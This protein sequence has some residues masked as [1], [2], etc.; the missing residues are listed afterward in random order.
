MLSYL[1][2]RLFT[3]PFAFLPYRA[4]HALGKPLGTLAY[5]LIPKYRKR[6]LSNLALSDLNLTTE[7]LKSTAKKSLQSL[8]ITVL[9][10]PKLARETTISRIVTCENPEEADAIMQQG[11]GVIFFCGHQANWELLF[12]E[13]T[14][15]MP[16]VAIGRPTKNK[17][18]Y[19]WVQG[20]RQKFG[21]TI[22]A[23]KNALKEGLR[24]LKKGA[25]LGIVGDQGM[26]DSGYHCPFL[27]REAWTS[28]APAMLSYKTNTPLIV[29]TTTRKNGRYTIH[30]EKALYPDPNAPMEQEIDRLMRA[31]LALY[32]NSIRK[33]PH[34]WLW[35][36]NRWKQQ[37]VG[38]LKRRYREDSIA[39]FLP[40]T[41][42]HLA[43]LPLLRELYPTE[44]I[45]LFAPKT[46][47]EKITLDAEIRPYTN[48][49]ELLLDDY[50][51]KL[52]FDL[53]CNAK[54]K[55]HYKKRSAQ[56]IVHPKTLQ[57]LE[58]LVRNA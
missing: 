36:H 19:N 18:L 43:D 26:P 55:S 10:Y 40:E 56:T 16:G 29:A 31:A 32:E 24:A 20:I 45:T 49:K 27:G 8:M 35:I 39:L 11:K 23:P 22:V 9:E 38:A 34:E 54:I 12:L 41:E 1:I 58:T 13:G 17:H 42:T 44:H 7:Q 14:S 3:L 33:H 46:L 5:Y 21:G 15:R 30:Y 4:I 37:P 53:T 2:L 6:A 25:F 48:P 47:A 57:A 50:R 28:P 51:F 52:I